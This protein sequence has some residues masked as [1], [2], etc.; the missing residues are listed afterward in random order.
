MPLDIYTPLDL[1]RIMF[2]PRQTGSTSQWLDMFF[3][4]T[5]TFFSTQEEIAFSRINSTRKIAPFMLPN[6]AG[7]P[8]YRR[9]GERIES[10]KPAYTKPKDAIRPSEMLSLMPGELVRR[11]A[12]MT[13]QARYNSEVLR[14]VQFQRNAIQRLYDFMAARAILNGSLVVNYAT[15]SGG[16]GMSVTVDFGRDAGHTITLGPGT[17]WGDVG[18]NIFG[19]I[20][21][22][23]DTVANA[24]FG[25]SVTDIILGSAA[26]VPF[27]ADVSASTGSLKDKMDTN[28]RGSEE[29]AIQRGIIATDPLNP[30]TWLGRLSAGMNVWRYA[31]PLSRFQNDDGSFTNIMDP[32][33]VLLASR[34]VDGV[35][36]FG[37]IL[38]TAA[39]LEVTDIFTKMWDQEDPS[40][41]FIMSQSAPLMIPVNPNCTFRARVVA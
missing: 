17:R 12:L 33:D 15:A 16:P 7:K 8:I 32:R 20:Q 6:E 3:P 11:L 13:P 4:A 34:A 10:F 1:Y 37:A 21:T 35:R 26:A 28:F 39:N 23:V 29:V 41:R 38:D 5:N 19:T 22:W 18:V 30:F 9:D 40:A 24:E 14:I 25:G 31:G 27:L 2:D 36:A